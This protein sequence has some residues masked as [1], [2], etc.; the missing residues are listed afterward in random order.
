MKLLTSGHI[1]A[2]KLKA[3]AVTSDKRSPAFP[4]LPTLAESAL[5]G[6]NSA[7]WIGLLAP[8]GTPQPVVDA[9]AGDVRE[10]LAIAEVKQRL[11]D[12]GATPVGNT[13]AQFT[14][15]I[16]NDRRRYAKIIQDKGIKVE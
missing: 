4:D 11:I 16:D 3:L 5:P 10:V 14:A 13:P 7:S 9:I 1:K 8:T 2:G 12:Q 6:F 15:L